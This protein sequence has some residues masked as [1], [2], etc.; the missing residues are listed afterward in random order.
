MKVAFVEKKGGAG[1]GHH[2]H[3][4]RPGKVGGSSPDKGNVEMYHGTSSSVLESILKYG[5]KPAKTGVAN[6]WAVKH[7]WI[8]NSHRSEDYKASVFITDNK[9]T[10]STYATMAADVRGDE[11]I[12]LKINVPSSMVS[13][14]IQDEDASTGLRIEGSIPPDWI[15]ILN[16]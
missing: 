5:L 14:F 13:E 3:A 11:P 1:S 12:M 2:G 16:D 6:E 9:I 15:S 4:G 10:A 7:G 8:I